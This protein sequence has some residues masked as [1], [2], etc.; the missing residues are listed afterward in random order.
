M[1]TASL[2]EFMREQR[3]VRRLTQLDV[4]EL[5]GVSDRFLREVEQG[6]PTAE[7]GKVIDVLAVLGYE[8]KPVAHRRDLL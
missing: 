8:L 4:A 3:K 5:A 1:D 7:I 2:G 6:K